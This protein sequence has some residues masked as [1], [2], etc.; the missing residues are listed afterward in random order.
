MTSRLTGGGPGPLIGRLPAQRLARRELSQLARLPLWQRVLNF[1]GR[2]LGGGQNA[3][4]RGWFGLIVFAILVAALIV[5]V[6]TWT[7]PR[8]GRRTRG[9]ALLGGK[10]RT[11]AEYRA[12]AGR[13]AGA[14]DYGRAIVEGVRAIAAELEERGILLARAGRTAN[15]VAAEA[16][17]ELPGLAGDLGAVTRLFDD[18]R[19]GGRPGTATAFEL[20][21]R[22][23]DQVRAARAATATPAVDQQ[24]GQLAVPR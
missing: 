9:S 14:G 2:L 23:D 10:A 6:M 5:V 16:G 21:S 3:I 17:A 4:P 7:R 1:I 24:P 8:A 15:E 19:Y 12:E 11:A 22:V 18:V 20:V 13:F